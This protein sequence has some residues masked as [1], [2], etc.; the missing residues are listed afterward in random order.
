MWKKT[1]F[2]KEKVSKNVWKIKNVFKFPLKDLES[3]DFESLTAPGKLPHSLGAQTKNA[4]Q[5]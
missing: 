3:K 2:L 4:D 1:V 5:Q